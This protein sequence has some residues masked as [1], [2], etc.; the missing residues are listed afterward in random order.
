MPSLKIHINSKHTTILQPFV[1]DYLDNPV[2]EEIFTHLHLFLSSTIFYQLL[3]S[4]TAHS[5]FPVQFT[6]LTVYRQ[7]VQVFWF[8]SW[9]GTF[10]FI[11]HTFL[12]PFIIFILQ[13]MPIPLQPVSL[14]TKITW[15]SVSYLNVTHPSDHSH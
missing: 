1:R 14:Y 10:H 4:T 3:P 9:S 7:P 13:H 12:H 5:I 2:P 11:L 15:N 6:C 8:T